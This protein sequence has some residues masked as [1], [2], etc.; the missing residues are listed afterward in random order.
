MKVDKGAAVVFPATTYFADAVSGRNLFLERVLQEGRRDPEA[1]RNGYYFDAVGVNLYCSLETI[2][3]V[4]G[5][6]TEILSRHGL[7]NKPIWLT[8]TNCPIYNDVRAPVEQY[9]A[10][11]RLLQS[12]ASGLC[13]YRPHASTGSAGSRSSKRRRTIRAAT[14]GCS[15]QSR[16]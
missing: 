9:L 15:E 5:L 11:R 13:L 6:Y 2:Y 7:A 8:E 12:L 16:R 14:R 4:R 3:R 1:A 10:E